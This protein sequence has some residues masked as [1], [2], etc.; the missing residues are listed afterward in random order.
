MVMKAVDTFR[1]PDYKH[2]CAQAVAYK[3]R[4]LYE[5]RNIVANY[6]P[7][8]GGCAPGGLC[9]AL[10]AAKEACPA[11]AAE[12]EKLFVAKCGAAT[13]R[14]IKTGTKTPCTVCVQVADDLLEQFSK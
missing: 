14:E 10:Y 3:W 12:I 13:C 2:N 9:G 7:Y 6:A 1:H 4:E 8:V 11:S 5:D